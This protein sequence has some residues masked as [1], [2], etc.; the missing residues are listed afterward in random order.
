MLSLCLIKYIILAFVA[1]SFDISFGQ[2]HY[3]FCW[4]GGEGGV[5]GGGFN[6]SL[7]SLKS[8]SYFGYILKIKTILIWFKVP[9]LNAC[10]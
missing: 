2:Q 10:Y 4:G 9:S 1:A 6:E 8:E 3:Y 7:Q 5:V